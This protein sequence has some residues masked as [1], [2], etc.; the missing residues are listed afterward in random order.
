M[1]KL[2]IAIFALLFCVAARSE[3]DTQFAKN[4]VVQAERNMRINKMSSADQY[5]DYKLRLEARYRFKTRHLSRGW[6]DWVIERFQES[7]DYQRQLALVKKALHTIESDLDCLSPQSKTDY[8]EAIRTLTAVTVEILAFVGCSAI[9]PYLVWGAVCAP[10][11]YVVG[12]LL[13]EG[14][15]A[16]VDGIQCRRR[17][18]TEAFRELDN[19]AMALQSQLKTE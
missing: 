16:A 10:V 12:A 4:L 5:Y 6:Q 14:I 7:I 8:Q 3:T 15:W 1:K 18:E 2:L 11:G 19:K 13:G 17:N 9:P